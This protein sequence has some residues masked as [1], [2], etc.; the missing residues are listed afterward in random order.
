MKGAP[1]L[2]LH[3]ALE[4]APEQ[5]RYAALLDWGTRIGLAVLVLTY[6]A[7]VL[8]VASPHVPPERLAELWSQPLAHYLQQTHSPTGWG[9]VALAHRGDV[10]GLLGISALAGCSL[11]CLL[12]LVPLYLR[13]GDRAFALLCLAQAAVVLVAASG[14]L[15]QAH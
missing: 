2:P 11:A 14:W 10:A 1:S 5:L 12:G 4:Q 8:G 15:T 6:A 7:C 3:S 9:W 13:R